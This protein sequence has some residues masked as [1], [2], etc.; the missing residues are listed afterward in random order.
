MYLEYLTDLIDF[1]EWN[2]VTLTKYNY[3]FLSNEINSSGKKRISKES[4][5]SKVKPLNSVK[6]YG[7]LALSKSFVPGKEMSF[8][9][10][11]LSN[12]TNGSRWTAEL[13]N[14][15]DQVMKVLSELIKLKISKINYAWASAPNSYTELKKEG[16]KRRLRDQLVEDITQNVKISDLYFVQ[17]KE[18][19]DYDNNIYKIAKS[20]WKKSEAWWVTINIL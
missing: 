8:F 5:K 20:S 16:M 14:M 1:E 4:R 12:P 15:V 10:L 17:L 2:L 11:G 18:L 19:V 6:Q 9:F 13:E 7:V 3:L